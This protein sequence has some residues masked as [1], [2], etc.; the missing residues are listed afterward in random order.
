M[1]DITAEEALAQVGYALRV[2]ALQDAAPDWWTQHRKAVAANHEALYLAANVM[3]RA[4]AAGV[5]PSEGVRRRLAEA[6]AEKDALDAA[7]SARVNGRP[8][9]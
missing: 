2:A 4:V 7:L 6:L 1:H 5:P 8:T 3:S 9:C